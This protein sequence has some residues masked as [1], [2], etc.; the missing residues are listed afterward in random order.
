MVIRLASTLFTLMLACVCACAQTST[1]TLDKNQTQASFQVRRVP[2]SYVRGSF[3]GITGTV[4]WDADKPSNSRVDVV[5][6]TAS[7]STNNSARDADLKSSN[8]FNVEKY[9]TM[10][11]KST[12]V[13]GT[14][15]HLQVVGNLTLAG[16]TKVVT[17]AVEGPTPPT[18]MGK[19]I[20][21]FAA[22]G[23]L[24]RSDFNFAAKYPAVILGDEIR[25][26]ID[27]EA[28]Q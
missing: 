2:V 15:G 1:W 22:S 18:K 13:T 9:P 5:I 24:R 19:I 12:A 16:V 27:A 25:F 10:T 23:T 21:G 20:V 14:P 26:T 3:S 7:I 28:N 8:F 6:P 4:I 17:L 11:F